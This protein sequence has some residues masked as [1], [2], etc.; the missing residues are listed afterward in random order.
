MRGFI[1]RLESTRQK[2]VAG[3][4]VGK[5]GSRPRPVRMRWSDSMHGQG[6]TDSSAQIKDQNYERKYSKGMIGHPC[7]HPIRGGSVTTPS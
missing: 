1:E 7:L 5:G 6:G 2:H 4:Y 3:G